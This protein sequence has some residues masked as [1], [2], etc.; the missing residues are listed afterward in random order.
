MIEFFRD[1]DVRVIQ[2]LDSGI[3]P[4]V[5]IVVTELESGMSVWLLIGPVNQCPS[6]NCSYTDGHL[7]T[8]PIQK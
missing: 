4:L 7:V 3:R 1:P 2:L 5:S 6:I 8:F